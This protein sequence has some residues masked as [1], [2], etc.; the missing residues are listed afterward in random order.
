[1]TVNVCLINE[2][3]NKT[4]HLSITQYFQDDQ[5]VKLLIFRC[6]RKIAKSDYLLCHICLSIHIKQINFHWMD[7]IKYDIWTLF[8]EVKSKIQ[9]S[10]KSDKSNGSLNEDLRTFTIV[11]CWICLRMRNISDKNCRKNQ[12]THFMYNKLFSRIFAFMG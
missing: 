12:N 4:S 5:L 3:K 6:I 11:S 10:L 7:L 9:V 8:E 1:M 2:Y